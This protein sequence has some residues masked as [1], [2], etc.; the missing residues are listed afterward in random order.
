MG[1]VIHWELCKKFKFDHT[2]KWYM[3]NPESVLRCT[4]FIGIL[5]YTRIIHTDY[6]ISARQPDQ[7]I[8][9]QKKKKK[10]R[11]KTT[12]CW[13]EDSDVPADHRVKLKES[14]KRDKYLDLAREQKSYGTWNWRWY[15]RIVTGTG[16]LGNK[17]TSGEHP[18]YSIIE[19]G[20]DTEKC[21]GDLK[22]LAV[23]QPPVEN[24]RLT[25]MWRALKLVKQ[26]HNIIIIIIIII[27]I[28]NIK[29]RIN[30]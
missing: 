21:P 22:R 9:N 18:N 11:E 20:Q 5:R 12:T 6:L 25:L 13:I 28:K 14:E 1:K 23:T 2:N 29:N 8:V 7:V 17:R 3:L 4:K 19:I 10:K 15:Q 27:I 30:N 26:K 16:G 24:H